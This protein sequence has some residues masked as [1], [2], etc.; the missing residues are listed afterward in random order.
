M[1][2]NSRNIIADDIGDRNFNHCF[3]PNISFAVGAPTPQ[4]VTIEAIR[5]PP[6]DDPYGVAQVEEPID[7]FTGQ[8]RFPATV[9]FGVICR[10]EGLSDRDAQDRAENWNRFLCVPPL[11]EIVRRHAIELAYFRPE[12]AD[13]FVSEP[14]P[15]KPETPAKV[16]PG[17]QTAP[18]L[19][20][21]GAPSLPV[22]SPAASEP[23]AWSE[24][25]A[26]QAAKARE[27]TRRRRAE[28]K[29]LGLPAKTKGS[30]KELRV[31]STLESV[32]PHSGSVAPTLENMTPS[33]T[34]PPLKAPAPVAPV[35]LDAV[36][37]ANVQ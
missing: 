3:G 18:A 33:A 7:R 6:G 20:Q 15:A 22:P 8:D 34:P 4:L 23:T 16:Q 27:R 19:P 26:R 21:P 17:A 30:L 32:A 13:W 1:T 36:E 5:P 35:T 10:G 9:A 14:A 11:D 12:I 29:R 2:N 28:L 25:K 31:T 24:A 37:V